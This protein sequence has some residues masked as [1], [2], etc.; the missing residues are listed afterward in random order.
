MAE[1]YY[2]IVVKEGISLILYRMAYER[3][4][5]FFSWWSRIDQGK[6][7]DVSLV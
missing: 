6:E 1:D 4:S 2:V 3:V 5:V 7:V